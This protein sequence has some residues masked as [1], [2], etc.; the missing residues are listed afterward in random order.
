MRLK[1]VYFLGIKELMSLWR[2]PILIG[3]IIFAFTITI[4]LGAMTLPETLHNASLSIVDEDQSQLSR[5][6]IDAFYPPYF[7]HPT[8]TNFGMIDDRMNAGLDSF[9]I[10]IPAHFEQ[11]VLAGKKP[12][13]LLNI[14]ATTIAEAFTGNDHIQHIIQ[15][16]VADFLQEHGIRSPPP[17]I[18]IAVRALFNP[19]LKESWFG[20]VMELI[21][22][23]T[24][25][26]IILTGAALI[27]EK[28]H[29]TVEH[30]LVMPVTPFE[31]IVSKIWSMQ[32]VV[33]VT[34]FLSLMIVLRFLISMPIAGSLSLF[35]VGMLLDLFATTTLGIFL[36]TF[37][38]SMPQFA[39]ILILVIL[40]MQILSGS[41]TPR[42]SMPVLIQNI[43]LATPNTNFV[44]LSLSI[45]YRG[46]GITVVWP[47]FLIL[48]VIGALLFVI[49]MGRFRKSLS[50]L[51]KA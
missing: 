18:D 27:R 40:P 11:D 44:M 23:I 42:E 51:R 46:A 39:L 17:I 25:L 3:F 15:E 13:I 6:I 28:E 41:L 47:Q 7:A 12:T 24:L 30:L 43:M 50:S 14:D 26:S 45:L 35:M 2:D 22:S 5:R 33:L 36:G 32:L 38:R 48:F 9:S 10:V 1:N 4:Y 19:E 21:N 20:G 34:S 49:S 31:I 29:G 16:E 8:L 37:A